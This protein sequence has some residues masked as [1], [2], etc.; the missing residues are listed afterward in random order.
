MLRDRL[1]ASMHLATLY[2]VAES[3]ADRPLV[4]ALL[5]DAIAGIEALLDAHIPAALPQGRHELRVVQ[6]GRL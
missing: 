6:G 1:D 5:L 3:V 4:S 2:A